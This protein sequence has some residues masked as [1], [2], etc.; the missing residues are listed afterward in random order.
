MSESSARPAVGPSAR[1]VIC[2]L[3]H[4]LAA[5]PGLL[6]GQTDLPLS[7]EGQEQMRLL[8]ARLADIPFSAAWSSPL[9]RARQSAALVLAQNAGALAEARLEPD[10]REIALGEWEGRDKDWI[11]RNHASIWAARGQDFARSAPPG[12]ESVED[13]ASRVRPAFKALVQTAKGHAYSLIT[14]HQAVN[15]VILA[16]LLGVALK[17][18]RSI[19]QP[20]AAATFL[21]IADGGLRL[22]P[23]TAISY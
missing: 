23:Q 15:R 8:A 1:P 9:Q 14:A 7:A 17:D 21:E 2:L 5:P 10:L 12:G 6:I 13:L 19:E 3:R 16:D 18:M 11:K 4:G 20:P 22:L